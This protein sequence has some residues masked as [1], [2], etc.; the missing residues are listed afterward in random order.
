MRNK[1][2][3]IIICLM[4]SNFALA[5]TT[6]K[7]AG[8]V[9]DVETDEVL[10][11]VNVIVEGTSLGA[12]TASDGYYAIINVPPGTYALKVSMIGYTNVTVANVVVGIHLTTSIDIEVNPEVL[13]LAEVTVVAERPVVV[14]DISHSQLNVESEVIETM[15]VTDVMEV[16]GLQA[17]V[18][19]L[20][21]RGGSSSQTAFIVDG[22]LF[23][24]ERSNIPYTSISLSAVQEVQ[25]Q[26]GGFNAEYGNIRSGVV[27]IINSEGRKDRY[28]GT[29][30]V[31]Y[32]PARKKHFGQ[33]PYD[34]NSYFLR[35]YLDPAVCWTG[36]ASGEPYEDQNENG[37]WD[38]GER[39]TDL[40]GDGDLTVWDDYTR[41]QYPSFEGWNV[42]SESTLRDDNPD[43][44]LTPEGAKKLFE[45]QHR[46]QGDIKKSD[47][48][49][50][51]AFGGPVPVISNRLGNLRFNA[52]YRNLRDMFI[53]PLSRDSYDEDVALLKLTSDIRKDI[54]LT[55]IALY[56]EIH[57]TSQYNWRPTPTGDVLRSDY[58]I[59]NLASGAALFVPGYYS[60]SSIYRSI[61]GVKLN[62]MLSSQTFYEVIIQTMKNR[63]HTFKMADRDTT[64]NNEIV[65]DFYVDEAPYGYW[66]G[67]GVNAFGD[68]IRIGGWMNLG[69]DQSEITTSSAR[70]DITSQVNN[71][72]QFRS[73]FEI[74]LNNYDI[75]SFTSNPH[76]STWNR[77]QV[78]EITPYRIGAYVHDKMEFEGLIANLS[79]RLD[80]SDANSDRFVLKPYDN[81]MKEGQGKL[82]EKE[83]DRKRAKHQLTLSPKIGISHPITDNSKLYFNYGHYRSEPSSTTRFRLQ[84][85]Y[86]GQV[87][88][89]GDPSLLLEKT[90]A[91]ELG[92][93]HNLFNQFLVNVAAYYKDITSQIGWVSYEN[94]NASVDY[95]RASNNQYQDTRGFEITLDKRLGRWIT[96]FINYTYMVDTYGYFG[97]MENYQNPTKQR[98]YLEKNPYQEKPVPRPYAR[99]SL[100]FHSPRDFGPRLGTFYPAGGINMNLLAT[101]K[102]GSYTTYNPMYEPGLVNNVQWKDSYNIDLRLTK[103][104]NIK[105]NRI[106]CYVDIINALNLKFLSYAGFSDNQDYLS[107]M[108]SLH[109]DWE[110]GVEYGHDRVGEYRGAG[111]DY[112]PMRDV[113]DDVA[114]FAE[115]DEADPGVVYYE[116]YYENSADLKR[117]YWIFE[118]GT[119]V[120]N[121]YKPNSKKTRKLLDDKAYIDMP[122]FTSLTFL[123]PRDIRIGIQIEF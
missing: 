14:R 105:N 8:F 104:F 57:S 109:F 98:E 4:V 61:Y 91:Y 2:I 47:Y 45:W 37:Q 80:L 92:Y 113:P 96:G 115:W 122:N 68:K 10:V 42:I 30:E 20:S 82:I 67:V 11:G 108:A 1:L 74:V 70:F 48:T 60:P 55:L 12:A 36:T 84:R 54:K 22:F 107:Y 16:I 93:S 99:A 81:F 123:N 51:F 120:W 63:Y 3:G 121:D 77:D 59:A 101:W 40:N 44:D 50:D 62:H 58:G 118:E 102:A 66:G 9:T 71:N 5:G 79:L 24:D 56:G 35:P 119:G 52:S 76:M 100:D 17:G 86:N 89:I 112:T 114:S 90:V 32:K 49:L 46:R 25:V 15:P 21:I 29:F 88:S 106:L 18:E 117:R 13:G 28:S 73:G 6:G 31:N 26:T 39:F 38:E 33:S 94:V 7:I 116:R 23:N 43:N 72:N 95:A 65:E 19:G 64:K 41:R 27:N 83:A 110:E 111:V 97:L 87:T 53:I 103:S 69:R 75:K 78:Y 34:P 85:E